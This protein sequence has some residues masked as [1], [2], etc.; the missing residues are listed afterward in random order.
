MAHRRTTSRRGKLQELDFDYQLAAKHIGLQTR[1]ASRQLGAGIAI[2]ADGVKLPGSVYPV[3]HF[4]DMFLEG[5]PDQKAEQIERLREGRSVLDTVLEASSRMQR[6][7][8]QLDRRKLDEYF[9][10]V[11]DAE[12]SLQKSEQWHS[13]PKPKVDV[14]PP[15]DPALE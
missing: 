14:E 12:Q 10:A 15:N 2:S 7:V 9:T 3:R 1:F 5:R 11:R 6:R 8:S 4:N 13:K